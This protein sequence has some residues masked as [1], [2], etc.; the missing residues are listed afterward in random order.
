MQLSI[1]FKEKEDLFQRLEVLSKETGRSKT[2]Y[3]KAAVKQYLEDLED[4]YI[5]EK[6]LEMIRAG[7]LKTISLEEVKNRNGLSNREI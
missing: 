4:I 6:K 5:A 1:R 2:Y 3:V 7:E